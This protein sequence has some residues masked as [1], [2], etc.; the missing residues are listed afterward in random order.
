M[1]AELR[2]GKGKEIFKATIFSDLDV[3]VRNK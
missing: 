1:C 2:E 3:K